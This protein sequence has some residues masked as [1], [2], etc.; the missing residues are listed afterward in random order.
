MQALQGAAFRAART[1][2]APNV[3]GQCGVAKAAISEEVQF[4]LSSGSDR[5]RACVAPLNNSIFN[6]SD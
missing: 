2:L 1:V 6:D 4:P 5:V 3:P